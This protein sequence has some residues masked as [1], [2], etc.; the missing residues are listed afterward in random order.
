VVTA[1]VNSDGKPDLIAAPDGVNIAVMLGKGN[2]HFASPVF[3]E[4]ANGTDST[5][6]MAVGDFNRDGK[7]DIA[8]VTNPG[9]G[10]SF[11]ERAGINLLAGDGHGG[12]GSPQRYEDV[13]SV[14][15]GPRSLVV[16]D[17]NGDGRPDLV[18]S[19]Y[20]AVSV[21][22]NIGG[23]FPYFAEGQTYGVG[24]GA[25]PAPSSAAL[26]DFNGDH[27]LDLAVTAKNNGSVTVLLGNGDGTFAAKPDVFVDGDPAAVAVGDVNGDGKLDLVT[28]NN[29]NASVLLGNGDG[30]FAAPQTY[31]LPGSASSIALGDF[32]KDG[33][34]DVVTTG[35]EIDVLLNNG[36]G[37]FG[38]A[39]K[40]G[41]AGSL[42]VVA[43]F[44]HDGFPD[45]A[46]LDASGNSIDVLLNNGNW[47]SGQK[48]HKQ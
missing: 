37:T 26:A 35:S 36:D 46:Q 32:N 41:P 17:L 20:N 19:F 11:G 38:A 29:G 9:D 45:L 39:Q 14:N 4:A 8:V 21:V 12:F 13:F 27:K 44:N 6:A 1:D 47:S 40:A 28:A 33:K 24:G 16:G 31:T 30:T 23:A 48:G 34:L 5:G 3:Y 10:A 25:F 22:M 2:G 15:Y 42:L 18:A 7:L 43:D